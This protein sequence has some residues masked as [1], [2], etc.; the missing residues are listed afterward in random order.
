MIGGMDYMEYPKYG[1]W[2][3]ENV[4][5]TIKRQKIH[6][7]KK[8][9]NEFVF[10]PKSDLYSTGVYDYEICDILWI[11]N[12]DSLSKSLFTAVQHE[13]A[14]I[15]FQM[16]QETNPEI[17][18]RTIRRNGGEYTDLLF[19]T[20][21]NITVD[22]IKDAV[23]Y[24]F[25]YG[26]EEVEESKIPYMKTVVGNIVNVIEGGL[27]E[28]KSVH[29]NYVDPEAEKEEIPVNEFK[30]YLIHLNQSGIFA[31]TVKWRYV[32]LFDSGNYLVEGDIQ[33]NNGYELNVAIAAKT[34]EDKN[35]VV[36]FLAMEE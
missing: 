11:I 4:I 6:D 12:D 31:D 9:L 29:I 5:A 13:F 22:E 25:D 7:S 23:M 10:N 15:Y 36:E 35:K 28:V 3:K 14:E 20:L 17:D 26:T 8:C 2:C 32:D 24:A 18:M 27:V 33:H 1:T 19:K 21:E 16:A 34:I 30:D